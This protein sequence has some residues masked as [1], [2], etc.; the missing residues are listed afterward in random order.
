MRMSV[1]FI[2]QGLVI[3]DRE[4]EER[5]IHASGPGGQN[6]NKV[7]SAVQLRFD[8]RRSPS[9]PEPVRE[10]LMRMAG[11]RLSGEG[12]L[13]ITARRHREQERNRAEARA[14]LAALILAAATPRT[15][16]RPTGVPKASKRHR[17]EAKKRRG[18]VKQHRARPPQD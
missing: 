1:L 5:F 17:L 7:A 10:A 13:L 15:P 6:V 16:R 4:L 8:V 3:P 2:R 18:R 12:V 11:G 9:L 14:R